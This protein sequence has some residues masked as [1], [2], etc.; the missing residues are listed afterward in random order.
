MLST[1]G[2]TVLLVYR[3]LLPGLVPLCD[4]GVHFYSILC[5]LVSR[6]KQCV[7][8][9]HTGGPDT[10]CFRTTIVDE[11]FRNLMPACLF[12]RTIVDRP[13]V[14]IGSDAMAVAYKRSRRI[15]RFLL[16]LL[17][18]LG[19]GAIEK[20]QVEIASHFVCNEEQRTFF[21]GYHSHAHSHRIRKW[22]CIVIP[23][24][25]SGIAKSSSANVV[26]P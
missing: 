24:C 23:S 13:L 1:I 14:I 6:C 19:S 25:F 5:F 15:S 12:R 16:P 9:V 3:K 18:K 11:R 26:L 10:T 21:D 2:D 17:R 7:R 4:C 8:Q 22:E 20:S